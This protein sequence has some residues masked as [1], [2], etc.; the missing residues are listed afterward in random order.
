MK[1]K[2]S[3]FLKESHGKPR[4]HI[5]KQIYYFAKKDSYNQNYGFSKSHV[6]MWELDHKEGWVVR[7]FWTVVL[8]KTL[9]SP[10]DC[11]EIKPVN[12]KGNQFWLFIGMEKAM[13]P[14]SSTL[15]WK[16]PWT[17]EPGRLQSVGSLRVRHD[18]VTSLSLFI[19]MHW[20][21]KW[22][23]IQ[24]SCLENPRDRGA[25]WAAVYGVSQSWTGL[26]R[27]SSSSSS[28]RIISSTRVF[29]GIKYLKVN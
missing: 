10:L 26:K 7:N 17:K 15:A 14:H 11:Q 21:R 19:F 6:W 16:I 27:L 28:K 24:C 18:W 29:K 9:E 4:Q 3:S 1:L 25:W 8:E 12:P 23:P 5:I 22:Q 13:A 20:R 2:D